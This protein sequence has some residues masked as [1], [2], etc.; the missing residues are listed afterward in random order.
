MPNALTNPAKY[1]TKEQKEERRNNPAFCSKCY[2]MK[3]PDT[4]RCAKCGNHQQ[5]YWAKHPDELID[6][7][8]KYFEVCDEKDVP[9]T[10]TGMALFIGVNRTFLVHS[11]DRSTDKMRHIYN[12]ARDRVIQKLEER[13]LAG[14]T[15]PAFAMF[16]LTNNTEDWKNEKYTKTDI[17]VTPADEAIRR[18]HA[19]I[20]QK[21]EYDPTNHQ[22][23][24]AREE[25]Y[26]DANLIEEEDTVEKTVEVEE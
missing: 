17:T 14:K 16:W 19:R 18:V 6:K 2:R 26:I 3:D 4:E 9:P 23:P 25:T 24:P 21:D 20:N 10:M 11:R 1:L 15:P 13:A 7:I 8:N 5:N 22:L 12:M